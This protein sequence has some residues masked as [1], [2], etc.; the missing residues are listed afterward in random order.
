MHHVERSIGALAATQHGLITFTQARELGLGRGQVRSRVTTG[1]WHRVGVGVYRL[2]GVPESWQQRALAACL[3][4]AGGAVASHLTAAALARL[5][6]PPTVPHIT[7][8]AG[9]SSSS[10]LAVVHRARRVPVETVLQGVPCTEVGRTLIDCA[11]ILGPVR[12][13]SVVDEAFHRR[14]VSVRGVEWMLDATRRAPGRPGEVRLRD[15]LDPWRT[16]I[17]AGSPAEHRLRL[18][19]VQWGYPE[20]ELQVPVIAADGSV[21]GRVDCGWPAVRIGIEYDSER[22]HG[23]SAWGSDVA[24]QRAIEAEGWRLLRADKADL[25]P[26]E[27]RLRGDLERVW[28]RAGDQ[29]RAVSWRSKPAVGWDR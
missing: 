7:V 18:Q 3:G 8:A 4:G 29:G 9:R 24:R 28:A 6:L 2:A 25:R 15:A 16:R 13:Q 12:L 21:L 27:R 1:R 5:C 11:S 23:E 20:P 17:A 19:L 22:F 10:A 26:G 14:L